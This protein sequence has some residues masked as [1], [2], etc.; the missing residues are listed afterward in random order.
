MEKD[1]LDEIE[2]LEQEA[3]EKT[4]GCLAVPDDWEER[5]KKKKKQTADIKQNPEKK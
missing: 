5:K 1:E 4:G 2:R 3:I